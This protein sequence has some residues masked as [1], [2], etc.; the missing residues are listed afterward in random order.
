MIFI[1]NI[2]IVHFWIIE[3]ILLLFSAL[4]PDDLIISTL[5]NTCVTVI[6]CGSITFV[7]AADA[8]DNDD[9]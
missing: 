4:F 2:N 3:R 7:F 5:Y 9:D 6:N 8:V 1:I